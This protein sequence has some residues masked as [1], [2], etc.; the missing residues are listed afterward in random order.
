MD[1]KTLHALMERAKEKPDGVWSYQGHPYAIKD[2]HVQLIG[3]FDKV[4]QVSYGFLVNRGTVENHY[5]LKD[6]IKRLYKQL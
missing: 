6:E 5:R 4:L 3:D 1:T 2:G